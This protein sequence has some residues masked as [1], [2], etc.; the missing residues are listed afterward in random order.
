MDLTTIL[1]LVPAQ[2]AGDAMALVSFVIASCALAMR[3]WKPPAAGS[4]W[5]L[6]YMAVSAIAQARGWNANAYQPGQ[7]AVMVPVAT[8]RT[9]AAEKLGL[10]P[11]DTRPK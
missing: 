9:E 11:D 1:A 8:D 5:T 4:K 3:F 2:Y 6:V 10:H 7:K